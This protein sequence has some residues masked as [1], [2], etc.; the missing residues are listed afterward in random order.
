MRPS[1]PLRADR[2]TERRLHVFRASET[3]WRKDF[4]TRRELAEREKM[5]GAESRGGDGAGC[6][7]QK[8][9]SMA[10]GSEW[11]NAREGGGRGSLN[12]V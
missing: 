11:R 9:N 1:R 5:S 4:F 6:H 7:S 12:E 8:R 3:S 10:G 2:T